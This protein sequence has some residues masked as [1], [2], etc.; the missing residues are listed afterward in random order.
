MVNGLRFTPMEYKE[1]GLVLSK[2][3]GGEWAIGHLPS[4][5]CLLI[6]DTMREYCENAAVIYDEVLAK[7]YAEY[8]IKQINGT[9]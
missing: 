5:Y 8:A 4:E 6:D 7:R 3:E 2:K 9:A 1:E